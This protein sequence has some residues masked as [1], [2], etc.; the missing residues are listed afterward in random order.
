M[1]WVLS[2]RGQEVNQANID[3]LMRE[4]GLTEVDGVWRGKVEF[5]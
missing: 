5:Q 2:M 3:A 1:V 4:C